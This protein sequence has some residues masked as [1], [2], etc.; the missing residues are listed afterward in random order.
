M[1]VEFGKRLKKALKKAGYSQAKATEK[2]ELSKNAITNYVAGRIPEAAILHNL[3]KLCNVSMEWLLTGEEPIQEEYLI[4]KEEHLINEEKLKY[5]V[6][7]RWRLSDQEKDMLRKYR[8]LD[9]RDQEDAR[10]NI[11]MKYRRLTKRGMSSNSRN[12][13]GGSGEEAATKEYA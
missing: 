3:A 2:L 7:E 11:E 13:G 5:E 4:N 1:S 8:Q 10:E 12:G 6:D 9:A